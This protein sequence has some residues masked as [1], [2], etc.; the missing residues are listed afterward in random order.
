M[1]LKERARHGPRLVEI[2]INSNSV[3]AR[4]GYEFA[5]I[6]QSNFMIRAESLVPGKGGEFVEDSLEPDAVHTGI[7]QAG[8]V[9][10]RIGIGSA[11][12]QRIAVQ[13][14]VGIAEAWCVGGFLFVRTA[15]RSSLQIVDKGEERLA[16]VVE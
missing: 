14:K 6:A 16:A 4:S 8:E 15:F 7:R 13:S 2:K 3:L 9:A 5:E 1:L 12:E 10:V 11:I